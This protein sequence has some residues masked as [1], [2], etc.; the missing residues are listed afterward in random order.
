MDWKYL[1]LTC[2]GFSSLE[3]RASGIRI[4]SERINCARLLQAETQAPL[5]RRYKGFEGNRHPE[6]YESV[7]GEFRY[8]PLKAAMPALDNGDL[9]LQF[10]RINYNSG[11]ASLF[12]HVLNDQMKLLTGQPGVRL[13]VLHHTPERAKIEAFLSEYSEALR[14]R[15]DLVGIG[16][17]EALRVWARDPS[18]ILDDGETLLVSRARMMGATSEE[19]DG[20]MSQKAIDD[21]YGVVLKYAKQSGLK[22]RRSLFRFE[23]GNVMTGE[24]NVFVGNDTVRSAMDDFGITRKEAIDALSKEFGKPVIALGGEHYQS[25]AHIDLLMSV[26]RDQHTQREVVVLESIESVQKAFLRYGN[27]TDPRGKEIAK[28]VQNFLR[29]DQMWVENLAKELKTVKSQL[30]DAGYRIQEVPGLSVKD[31]REATMPLLNYT[32]VIVSA[33]KVYMP[34][35]GIP[36]TDIRAAEVYIELGYD[37]I[38]MRSAPASF[39]SSGGPR[40]LTETCRVAR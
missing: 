30:L 27:V 25:Q 22:V 7:T 37:V 23:G 39:I 38:P 9:P 3:A 15:V 2:L 34:W 20:G 32:N 10:V 35:F 5:V 8:L 26:V 28:Q 6:L 17:V 1:V 18:L 33:N 21:Y 40:C 29:D 4:A 11:Q 19:L 14:E 16:D 31:Y 24:R 12:P 36:M 13:R